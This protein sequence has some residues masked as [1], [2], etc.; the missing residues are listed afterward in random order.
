MYVLHNNLAFM[1]VLSHHQPPLFILC[2]QCGTHNFVATT[3]TPHEYPSLPVQLCRL[4]MPTHVQIVCA[5][6]DTL[7]IACFISTSTV[8]AYNHN[9]QN[10]T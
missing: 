7:V 8:L 1:L 6:M 4:S 9:A 3:Y 5:R 2:N 10:Y